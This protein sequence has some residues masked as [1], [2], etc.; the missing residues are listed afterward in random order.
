MAIGDLNLESKAVIISIRLFELKL[1]DCNV[2]NRIYF[3]RANCNVSKRVYFIRALV[4]A[5]SCLVLFP[6]PPPHETASV[7]SAKRPGQIAGHNVD[8]NAVLPPRCEVHVSSA[9]VSSR[10]TAPCTLLHKD[11]RNIALV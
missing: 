1:T 9:D 6:P 3:I 8:S 2:S 4:R 10:S 7:S 11:G 5:W